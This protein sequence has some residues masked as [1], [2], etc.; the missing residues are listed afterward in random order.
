VLVVD[1]VAA[2]RL[3]L[4]AALA[5]AGFGHAEAADGAAAV[6]LAA[7]RPFAAVLMDVQMPGMDGLEA[8]R[9]IRALPPP[10]GRLRVIGITA[11]RSAEGEAAARAAGMD[12]FLAKPVS[13][14]DLARVLAPARV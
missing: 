4:G 13:V 1:D 5:R 2:N 9:R 10:A 6:A 7:E 11:D 3:L 12:D 8:T 14:A